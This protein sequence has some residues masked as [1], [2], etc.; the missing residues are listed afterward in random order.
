VWRPW[1]VEAGDISLLGRGVSLPNRQ[2]STHS[3]VSTV[4]T[5]STLSKSKIIITNTKRMRNE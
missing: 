3:T 2:G 5:V 1:S 4:S